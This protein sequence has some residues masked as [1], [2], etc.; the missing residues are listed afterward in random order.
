M[1]GYNVSCGESFLLLLM[2]VLIVVRTT[3][4]DNVFYYHYENSLL[5][6]KFLIAVKC[7]S[8]KFATNLHDVPVNQ[9]TIQTFENLSRSILKPIFYGLIASGVLDFKE[10]F[11]IAKFTVIFTFV[12]ESIPQEYF[13]RLRYVWAYFL[14]EACVSFPFYFIQAINMVGTKQGG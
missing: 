13:S 6:T 9:V 12:F 1:F 5:Y 3:V 2:T 7:G 14:L 4:F 8:A 11:E 10:L